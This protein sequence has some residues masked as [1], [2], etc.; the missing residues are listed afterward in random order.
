MGSQAM[1]AF[2][3]A[4]VFTV[5]LGPGA[6]R[7]RAFAQDAPSADSDKD[8][9]AREAKGIPPRATPADYQTRIKAGA[10]TLAAEFKGHSVPTPEAVLTSE[11]YVTVEVAL[12]GAAGAR[13][14][15]STGDFALRINGTR[16][17]AKKPPLATQPYAF[18]FKS[19]KDPAWEPVVK[20]ESKS[21][22]QINGSGNDAPPAAPKMPFPLVREMQQRVQRSVLPEGDRELPQAGLIFFYYPGKGTGIRSAELIYSSPAGKTTLD[23]NP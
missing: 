6:V 2:V 22:T 18:V 10:I 20:E 16:A 19:L 4:S 3:I 12:F 15:I 17:N 14:T 1:K 11:D 9:Q 7:T 13:A 8:T 21:K 5:V 23:L